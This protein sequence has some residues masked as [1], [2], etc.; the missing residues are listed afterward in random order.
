MVSVFVVYM[1]QRMQQLKV[2]SAIM[3]Q[4]MCGV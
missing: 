4:H 1:C 2:G 3:H